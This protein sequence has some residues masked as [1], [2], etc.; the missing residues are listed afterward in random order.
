VGRLAAENGNFGNDK[1]TKL[2]HVY[3]YSDGSCSNNPGTGGYGTI[4]IYNEH[5]KEL[6]GRVENTTNNRMELLGII[7]GF[8]CLKEK[9]MVTVVTDSKYVVDTINNN[10]KIKKNKDLWEQLNKLLLQHE[11]EFKW[12]KGHNGN[13]ENERCD[14]LARLRDE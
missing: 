13:P 4:L 3:L 14:Y 1:N 2:K 6:H 5:K 8:E 12:I 11:T 9:C 10:W 7:K